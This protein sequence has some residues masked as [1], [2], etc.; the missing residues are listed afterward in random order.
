MQVPTGPWP[1]DQ[2]LKKIGLFQGEICITGVEPYI[3]GFIG[4]GLGWSELECRVFIAK[5]IAELRDSKNHLYSLYYF[6]YG[7]KPE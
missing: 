1:K 3:L 6:V 5:V 2:K 4:K 7:R